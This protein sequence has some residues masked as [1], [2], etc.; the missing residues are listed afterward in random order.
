VINQVEVFQSSA[1]LGTYKF[2]VTDPTSSENSTI[3]FDASA[4][5]TLAFQM[6][7]P[8][9][10][11]TSYSITIGSGHGSGSGDAFFYVPTSAFNPANGDYITLFAQFGSQP[12]SYANGGN[13]EQFA[14]ITGDPEDPPAVPLPSSFVMLASMLPACG[15]LWSRRRKSCDTP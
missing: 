11:S 8:Q 9:T 14:A 12:G 5:A 15:F 7:A 1:D 6:S 13:P 3:T 10:S 2:T 4:N